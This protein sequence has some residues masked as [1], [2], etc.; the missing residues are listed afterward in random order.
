MRDEGTTFNHGFEKITTSAV[1]VFNNHTEAEAAIPL[2]AQVVFGPAD[3][4][5]NG[6]GSVK[7]EG[8]PGGKGLA[9]EY[10]NLYNCFGGVGCGACEVG[11]TGPTGATGATGAKGVTGATGA[12]G[13]TGEKGATG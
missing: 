3:E 10:T 5:V 6:N 13:A 4:H 7:F 11:H 12:K 8:Q 2:F 9:F 1:R